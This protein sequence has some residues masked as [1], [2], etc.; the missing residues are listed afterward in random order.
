[1]FVGAVE[2]RQRSN[3]AAHYTL[4]PECVKRDVTLYFKYVLLLLLLLLL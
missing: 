2:R 1:M 4:T 3:T